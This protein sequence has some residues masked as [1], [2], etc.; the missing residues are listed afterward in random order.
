MEDVIDI[1]I[2]GKALCSFK[3]GS[4][5]VYRKGSF[6]LFQPDKKKATKS[7]H[8]PNSSNKEDPVPF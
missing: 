2:K 8:A 3:D 5:L 7:I 6:Y 1:G 4:L